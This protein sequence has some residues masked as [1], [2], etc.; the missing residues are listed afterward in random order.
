MGSGGDH[1]HRHYDNNNYCYY[2]HEN[3]EDEDDPK[4]CCCCCPCYILS[5]MSRRIR[6]VLLWLVTLFCAALVWTIL[7]MFFFV[8]FFL[9]I[10][11]EL[12]H[13]WY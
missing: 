5:S 1:H 6:G 12:I 2:C 11:Y 9:G 8:N 10:Y 13:I 4:V 7:S 3:N